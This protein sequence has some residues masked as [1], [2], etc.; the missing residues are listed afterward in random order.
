MN[1]SKISNLPWQDIPYAVQSSPEINETD[2]AEKLKAE[3][4]NDM[5]RTEEQREDPPQEQERNGD[6]E[7]W[8]GRAVDLSVGLQN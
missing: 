1:M 4:S 2:A 3:V 8:M 7:Y 6:G 5:A